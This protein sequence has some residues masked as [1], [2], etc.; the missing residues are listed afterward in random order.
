MDDIK[1]WL[2]AFSQS[3]NALDYERAKTLFV[4]T[5]KYYG[6]HVGFVSLPSEIEELE[7][8]KEWPSIKNFEWN[9]RNRIVYESGGKCDMTVAMVGWT[10]SGMGI[11]GVPFTRA[12]RATL[13]FTKLSDSPLRCLHMHFTLNPGGPY[14]SYSLDELNLK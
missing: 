9:Y 8:R 10:A 12:G 3:V 4:E 2:A 14:K 7:W 6:I 13:I 5:A 11:T 1:I